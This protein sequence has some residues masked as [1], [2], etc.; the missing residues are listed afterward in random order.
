MILR[1]CLTLLL[2]LNIGFLAAQD[3]PKLGFWEPSDTFHK[4][5]FWRLTGG[6]TAVYGLVSVGLYNAWYKGYPQSSFH[7]FNDLGEWKEIDKTGHFLTAYNMTRG[8]FGGAR[9]VGMKHRSAA[10][11]AAGVGSL[12]QLTIEVMDGFSEKWGFSLPDIAF[13]T[14][15]A[16]LFLGQE[17]AWHEQR[18]NLKV[19]VTP[20]SYP[21]T[22]VWSTDGTTSV[23]LDQRAKELYGSSL[24]EILLKDYNA[25]SGWASFNI[26]S[27]LPEES[28]FPKWLNV[29]VGYGANNLYAGY[30]NTWVQD[31]KTFDGK[32]FVVNPVDY[33]VYRQYY[34]SF[35]VDFTR[36]RTKSPL[37]KFVFS[38]ANV[39][40]M[41]SPTLE[42]NSLGKLKLHAVYF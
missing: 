36:I 10:W 21:T 34:L 39:F 20:Q 19:S 14:A 33:P 16:G 12:I 23:T 24:P 18:I 27:F 22:T 8:A 29:A 37:L 9:Y 3:T 11:T 35:D 42:Y 5:R 32:T 25:I 41:P 4:G 1:F 28:K 30:D 26:A 40:K 7:L 15:G 17:L 38:L 6:T 2:L 13:N 31:G